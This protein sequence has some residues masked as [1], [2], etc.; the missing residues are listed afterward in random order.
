MGGSWGDLGGIWGASWGHLGGILGASWGHLG[1]ILGPVW[2]LEAQL[3]LMMLGSWPLPDAFTCIILIHLHDRTSARTLQHPHSVNFYDNPSRKHMPSL[4][5]SSFT[6]MNALNSP[7]LGAS[8][9]HLG[10]I[11]GPV[12]VLEAQLMLMML[13]SWPLPDA[14]TCIILIHL[15]DQVKAPLQ[16]PSNILTLSTSMITLL[17]SICLHLHHPHSLA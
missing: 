8:W 12:W 2:V 9:G 17:E 14:F 15:H 7:I 6:C 3:M 1:G 4:A 11:L 16:E 10:G 13:G 5:S